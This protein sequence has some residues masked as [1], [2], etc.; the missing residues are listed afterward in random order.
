M[1]AGKTVIPAKWR[2]PLFCKVCKSSVDGKADWD[3]SCCNSCAN[4]EPPTS[5]NNKSENRP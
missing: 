2:Y 5:V 4:Y 1:L 3:K